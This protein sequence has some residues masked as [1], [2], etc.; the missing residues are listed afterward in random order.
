MVEPDEIE[1]VVGEFRRFL[2]AA[3]DGDGKCQSTI[4]EIK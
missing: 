2:E 4:L 3:M 1:P